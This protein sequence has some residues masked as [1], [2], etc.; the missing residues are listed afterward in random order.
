MQTPPWGSIWSI[1]MAFLFLDKLMIM[2]LD[3]FLFFFSSQNKPSVLEYIL[4][5]YKKIPLGY[6]K[7][8]IMYKEK[9]LL[10][11]KKTDKYVITSSYQR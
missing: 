8:S 5:Q 6:R 4:H 10:C 9:N 1:K 7:E 2:T 11:I 3:V